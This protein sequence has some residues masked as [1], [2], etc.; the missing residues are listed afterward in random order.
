[1]ENDTSDILGGPTSLN[2]RDSQSG[3]WSSLPFG[4]KSVFA[5]IV[6]F[7]LYAVFVR[8][9]EI[10]L[11]WREK[12]YKLSMRRRHGIPD[13]DHRPFNV[14]YA[15]VL[16]A[17]QEDE[18]KTRRA[19]LQELIQDQQ[20][21]PPDQDIR[22]RNG[23]SRGS[24]PRSSNPLRGRNESTDILSSTGRASGPNQSSILASSRPSFVSQP[25]TGEYYKP[26]PAVR[27]ADPEIDN[28]PPKSSLSRRGGKHIDEGRKHD[29][30]G[31]DGPQHI[32]RER[33]KDRNHLRGDEETEWIG[34]HDSPRGWKRGHGDD[35]EEEEVDDSIHIRD[36]RQRKVSLDN[37]SSQLI[38]EDMDID[39][40]EDEL[41][42]LQS[43]S[44]GKKR[45]RAEA[46]STFGGDNEDDSDREIDTEQAR[47]RH[48]KRRTYA[49]RRSDTGVSSR[50]TKRDRELAEDESEGENEDNMSLKASRKK[51]G[52]K[53][54][55]ASQKDDPSDMS[56]DESTSR[57][58]P[59]RSIGEEWES[60]GVKYKI[61]PIGQRLRQTLVRKE[62]Q[63]FPMPEDSQH[64]DRQA[65]FEV[66]V[67]TWL[68]DEEYREA[69]DQQLLAWQDLSKPSAEPQTPT[70]E[71]PEE[72]P[73]VAGKDLLWNSTSGN[74]QPGT[75][76][77]RQISPPTTPQ[78]RQRSADLFG[79]S[80]ASTVGLRINPFA[81][82]PPAGKRISAVRRPSS[83]KSDGT[84]T[85]PPSPVG[86]IVHSL[87]DTTNNSPRHKAFSK[88]EKQDLEAKAMMKMRQANR[89]KEEEKLEKLKKEQE[90]AAASKTIP[91]ITV[92][93]ADDAKPTETKQTTF[94]FAK[95]PAVDATKKDAPSP[96]F[97]AAA[98]R[99][100]TQPPLFAP[101]TSQPTTKPPTM[102]VPATTVGTQPEKQIGGLFGSKPEQLN[103]FVSFG[104]STSASASSSTFP[105]TSAPAPTN[106]GIP[107]SKPAF[108][109][110]TTPSQPQ[111][112]QATQASEKKSEPVAGGSLL[113]RLAPS[114][115]PASA[116]QPTQPSQASTPFGFGKPPMMEAPKTTSTFGNSSTPQSSFQP[117]PSH[118]S[119][120]ASTGP[121][122][123]F[124]FG[125]SPAG[126]ATTA[127][128]STATKPATNFAFTTSSNPTTGKGSTT[129]SSTN[130][131][132][133]A[134]GNAAA[135]K[136]NFSIPPSSHS[137]SFAAKANGTTASTATTSA[138]AQH[139]FVFGSRP[140]GET[141][142]NSLFGTFGAQTTAAVPSTTTTP[143]QSPFE[144]FG[145]K[146]NG[147]STTTPT[148]SAFGIESAASSTTTTPGQSAFTFGTK[149]AGTSSTHSAFGVQSTAGPSA[150]AP[151][152][153]A[154]ATGTSSTGG[155]TSSAFGSNAFGLKPNGNSS[156]AP[157]PVQPALGGSF[158]GIN[159][160]S[161]SSPFGMGASLGKPASV[162]S[163]ATPAAS[164]DNASK[165]IF[166]FGIPAAPSS[167]TTP[168]M[169]PSTTP[170]PSTTAAT[171][172]APSAFGTSTFGPSSSSAFTFGSAP[173]NST[174]PTQA[175]TDSP[176]GKPA[177]PS[178]FGFGTSGNVFSGFGKT[179]APTGQQQQ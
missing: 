34:E 55:R 31:G 139:S 14:A 30:N 124:G 165:P 128:S 63:K 113:S 15:A 101:T 111:P 143:A 148:Q 142:S 2:A 17:R 138:P 178:A 116:A 105:A 47:P 71:S 172:G 18:E 16:R 89:L 44:R 57:G 145:A 177:N 46:G 102:S 117:P 8:M 9:R 65:N 26:N 153:S 11:V 50:G 91:T 93:R 40:G 97:P 114:S 133:P 108:S 94:P 58:R 35:Y 53:S 69:K 86:S 173:K 95:P 129:T 76:T 164:K 144:A 154:F 72:V 38:S 163:V 64:P 150:L 83:F 61:G 81:N 3:W 96:L 5:L 104:P 176:F 131:A 141:G 42:A 1:M 87:S 174:T 6:F 168:L 137:N 22:Q 67:E 62:K 12:S 4:A 151:T 56:M 119:S 166:S 10:F 167:S 92:T 88:W 112:A 43:F 134:T 115:A 25:V 156:S 149:P 82:P 80:T 75:S 77:P 126:G 159:S 84:S 79:S 19:R 7:I 28:S 157:A 66:Y 52:K 152:Q 118:P 147:T 33:F 74:S 68:T 51:R 120:T 100:T 125:K 107:T 59:R 24:S 103:S 73:P 160:T 41:S 98:A 78:T 130:P 70:V 132:S 32:Q 169:T 36:K 171:T 122:F 109:F 170:A 21:A 20:S 37:K 99:E 54:A 48:R 29:L 106:P 158:G 13:N 140:A 127:S 110:G 155:S 39:E 179:P 135:P 60:N 161:T 23:H 49:K 121:K 162:T 175:S 45:D 27:I 90:A 136:L 85:I 146:P 123:D